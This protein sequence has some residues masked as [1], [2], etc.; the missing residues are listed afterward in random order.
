MLPLFIA[1]WM[2]ITPP[3]H[4]MTDSTCVYLAEFQISVSDSYLLDLQNFTLVDDQGNQIPMYAVEKLSEIDNLEVLYTKLI[5]ITIPKLEYKRVYNFTASG[6]GT[7]PY[8]NNGYA[9]NLEN[10]PELI[11]K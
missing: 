4:L 6:M 1:A 2:T 5:A 9:D 10:S 8:F 7:F 11:I 3:T